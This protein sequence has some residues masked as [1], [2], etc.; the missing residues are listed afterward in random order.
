MA[1]RGGREKD[2][3]G[4][5]ERMQEGAGGGRGSGKNPCALLRCT[6]WSPTDEAS[7]RD[8]RRVVGRRATS[9]AP[10]PCRLGPLL[11]DHPETR[12]MGPVGAPEIPTRTGHNARTQGRFYYRRQ[13]PDGCDHVQ[14]GSYRD[15]VGSSPRSS[16]FPF[17]FFALPSR[18]FFMPRP[19]SPSSIRPHPPLIL[20][21]P[22]YPLVH[23][24]LLAPVLIACARAL[25]PPMTESC[26][27]PQAPCASGLHC[28]RRHSAGLKK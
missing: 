28:M 22:G 7:P 21:N 5:V 11:D 20:S 19:T 4:F 6:Y 23:L 16:L 18:P 10:L 15:L 12:L 14:A 2:R 13:G 24:P 27:G 8:W 25:S 3:D 9:E 1:W 26:A 17:S